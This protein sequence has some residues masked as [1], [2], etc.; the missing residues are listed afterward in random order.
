VG[1]VHDFNTRASGAAGGARLEE[2][3]VRQKIDDE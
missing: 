3:V 2:S 1:G